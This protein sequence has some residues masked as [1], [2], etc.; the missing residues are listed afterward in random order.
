MIEKS[1]SSFFA[2]FFKAAKIS[3]IEG[4]KCNCRN[5]KYNI[6]KNSNIF[7]GSAH[8]YKTCNGG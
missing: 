6:L 4:R 8:V 7:S 2:C 1:I 3:Y 5:L